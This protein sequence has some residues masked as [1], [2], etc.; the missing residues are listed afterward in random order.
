M[1]SVACVTVVSGL[2][3]IILERTRFIGVMKAMGATNRQLRHL[4]LYLS[5]MIVLRG[6]LWGNILAFALLAIQKL[7][8]ILKLDPATYYLDQVPVHFPGYQI[9]VINVATFMMCVLVLTVPTYVISRI[10]P[11]RSIKFE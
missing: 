8:G 9:L 3:I 5:G 4:F 10:H 1:I 6:L 2:L 11:A 7:F